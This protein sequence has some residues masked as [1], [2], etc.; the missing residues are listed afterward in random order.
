MWA[1]C[2]VRCELQPL[3]AATALALLH[4]PKVLVKA[5]L[6]LAYRRRLARN[7]HRAPDEV[8][9]TR[10][11]AVPRETRVPETPGTFFGYRKGD[12][13]LWAWWC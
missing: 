5:A 6:H 2:Q 7:L 11:L 13:S 10:E 3:L 8:D 1:L 9:D 12:S 4:L